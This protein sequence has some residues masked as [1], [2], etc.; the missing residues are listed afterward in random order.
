MG[1]NKLVTNH[2]AGLFSCFTQGLQDIMKYYNFH[3]YLPDE[4]DRNSQFMFYKSH[5]VQ[6]LIPELF[7]EEIEYNTLEYVKQGE[8]LLYS[9]LEPREYF[10]SNHPAEQQFSPYSQMRFE[11][12]KPFR[13]MYFT[14]S[15]KVID[16]VNELWDKNIN[17]DECLGLFHRANDKHKETTIASDEEYIDK[18]KSIFKYNRH[19]KVFV[20]P[21]NTEFLEM[22]REEF[23]DNLIYLENPYLYPSNKEK[24]N[25]MQ[26]PLEDR[27]KHAID[28]FASVL[29][30]S[31]CN[32][33]I[34]H[35]GNGSFWSMIYRG[36]KENVHQYLNGEWIN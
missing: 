21:D 23:G 3:G 1:L 11:D 6:S 13:E 10:M 19:K 15:I 17:P 14:P 7:E 2:N 18:A 31:K 29:L 35:S 33:V 8:S 34:L 9:K 25:F 27:P 30:L 36:H 24:C 5:P 26:V 28:F 12:L 16:R 22:C 32:S 20:L 4:W